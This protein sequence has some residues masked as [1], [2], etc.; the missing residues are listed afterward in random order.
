METSHLTSL[1]SYI[2]FVHTITTSP[3]LSDGSAASH[4]NEYGDLLGCT[5]F[6]R[7]VGGQNG[8]PDKLAAHGMK[9]I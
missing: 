8:G 6:K 9:Q 3:K 5:A 2:L 7:P 4:S 1:S